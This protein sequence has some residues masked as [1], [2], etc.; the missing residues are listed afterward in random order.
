MNWLKDVGRETRL[1]QQKVHGLDLDAPTG[2]RAVQTERVHKPIALTCFR[3][4]LVTC[5][6]WRFEV[7]KFWHDT[8]RTTSLA[9][10]DLRDAR[11]SAIGVANRRSREREVEAT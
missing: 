3:R 9:S 2:L 1:G 11:P 8:S 7:K 5:L 4:S 6:L 10:L